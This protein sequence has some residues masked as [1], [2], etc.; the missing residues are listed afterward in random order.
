VFVDCWDL[1]RF[2]AC[3]SCGTAR[4]DRLHHMNLHQ[5]MLPPASCRHCTVAAHT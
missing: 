5:Q 1:D 4:R 2:A 3:A